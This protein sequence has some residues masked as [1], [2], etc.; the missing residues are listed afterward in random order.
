MGIS[1]G[2][3]AYL[4]GVAMGKHNP[5]RSEHTRHQRLAA[6]P[7]IRLYDNPKVRDAL[8]SGKGMRGLRFSDFQ[9]LICREKPP[10]DI[11]LCP[12]SRDCSKCGNEGTCGQKRYKKW[13]DEFTEEELNEMVAYNHKSNLA[14]A[15][16]RLVGL[17]Y[18]IQDKDGC[19][20]RIDSIPQAVPRAAIKDHVERLVVG[21]D[22]GRIWSNGKG[23]F[24]YFERESLPDECENDLAFL[25]LLL[26]AIKITLRRIATMVWVREAAKAFRKEV[27]NIESDYEK[28][29]L[30]WHLGDH[31]R[32][33]LGN[34]G[35]RGEKID[36]RIQALLEVDVKID[37]RKRERM[38]K[39]IERTEEKV[40]KLRVEISRVLGVVPKE[41]QWSDMYE[42]LIENA[43]RRPSERIVASEKKM[44]AKEDRF[45]RRFHDSDMYVS[46]S[47]GPETPVVII[48]HPSIPVAF[49]DD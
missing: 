19:Y 28:L 43:E 7:A 13:R 48:E 11:R 18:L 40:K 33:H 23:Y 12:K 46:P 22:I 35:L 49:Y 1:Y 9:Y 10:F 26:S 8:S 44:L 41:K 37:A 14:H 42:M 38:E 6:S 25:S 16:R 21:C 39:E 45:L 2:I 47:K 34:V 24:F 29:H 4:G 17:E 20:V 32:R 31:M 30:R 5:R 15:L 3:Y 27:D 36:A